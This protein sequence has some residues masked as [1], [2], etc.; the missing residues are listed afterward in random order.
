[1][2][3]HVNVFS[4]DPDFGRDKVDI[5]RQQLAV[6][7]QK[8]KT[9]ETTYTVKTSKLRVFSDLEE[10]VISSWDDVTFIAKN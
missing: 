7:A 8:V 9:M 6:H 4:I 5:V 10:T 3:N 2:E 1:M